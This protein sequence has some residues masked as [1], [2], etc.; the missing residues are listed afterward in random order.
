M[1][2]T[3]PGPGATKSTKRAPLGPR[4]R[5]VA[6][7]VGALVVAV[8]ANAL[9]D[10]PSANPDAAPAVVVVG[11]RLPAA[12]AVSSAW[13]CAAGTAAGPNAEDLVLANLGV[14][15]AIATITVSAYDG[16]ATTTATK[17]VRVEPSTTHRIPVATIAAVAQPGI[18]VDTVGGRMVVEHVVRGN[19][20]FALTPCAT[21]TSDRW[22]FASGTTAKGATDTIS[23][24]NPTGDDVIVDV[25]MFTL[26]EGRHGA[27][28]PQAAQGVDVPPGSRVDLPLHELA[29]RNDVIATQIV[30]RSGRF[31]A[32]QVV[33]RDASSGPAG[34]AASLGA[35]AAGPTWSLAFGFASAA[36]SRQVLVFNPASRPVEL[37]VRTLLDGDTQLAPFTTELQEEAV[38]VVDLSRI[39]AD[40][41]Y[42]LAMTSTGPVV[43]ASDLGFMVQDGPQGI[44]AEPGT[45]IPAR[46]WA[47]GL[48]RIADAGGGSLSVENSGSGAATV[49]VTAVRDGGRKRV[50]A[51]VAIKA[52]SSASI[53]LAGVPADAAI[54]V[55][56]SEPVVVE[57]LTNQGKGVSLSPG[58]SAAN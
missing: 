14:D 13:Y 36:V 48:A 53:D 58:V 18:V 1:S 45:P 42:A 12:D 9:I 47:F 3:G 31:V 11:A 27:S 39:P 41:Q 28:Q 4:G 21:R 20:D 16:N 34:L 50:G 40:A 22:T 5:L 52:G 49:R 26:Q 38:S 33:M 30:A 55:T 17:Q 32:E 15:A 10:E 44:A 8:F 23:L 37:T 25:S 56:A 35:P 54:I 19:D 51:P 24:F 6:L 7:L 46:V 57:R 2:T 29:P 43:V